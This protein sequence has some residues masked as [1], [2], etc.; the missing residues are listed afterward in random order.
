MKEVGILVT[1]CPRLAQDAA[2]LFEVYWELGKTDKI[3]KR[4]DFDIICS[5]FCNKFNETLFQSFLRAGK[6]R[7]N[8]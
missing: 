5:L 1:N 3:P 7:K 2:I 8:T 4:F 6:N